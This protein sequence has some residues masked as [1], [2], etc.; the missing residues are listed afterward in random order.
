MRITGSL[1]RG[2]VGIMPSSSSRLR[3]MQSRDVEAGL[4]PCATDVVFVTRV[5]GTNP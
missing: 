1:D 5:I 3:V 4:K 2:L